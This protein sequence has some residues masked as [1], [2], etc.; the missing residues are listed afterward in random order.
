MHGAALDAASVWCYNEGMKEHT[1][2]Q[3]IKRVT[4]RLDP[5]LYEKLAAEARAQR[6]SLHA[7][8][9]WMLEQATTR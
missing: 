2:P 9:V 7:Q 6:R 4:L 5:A 8:V 1:T 3:A